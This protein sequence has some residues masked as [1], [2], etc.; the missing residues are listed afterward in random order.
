M[1]TSILHKYSPEEFPDTDQARR[2][3]TI[4]NIIVGV[5]GEPAPATFERL[6]AIHRMGSATDTAGIC[7]R[8][9]VEADSLLQEDFKLAPGVLGAGDILGMACYIATMLEEGHG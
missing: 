6:Q 3:F 7:L 1:A 5:P 8:A 9:V 2:I 4:L